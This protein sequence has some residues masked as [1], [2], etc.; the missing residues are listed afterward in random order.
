MAVP[1]TAQPGRGP[2]GLVALHVE[3]PP[4]RWRPARR[5][6]RGLGFRHLRIQVGEDPL[7]DGWVL[8]ARNDPHSTATGRAGLDVDPEDPLRALGPCHHGPAFGGRGLHRICGPRP[9]PS[10]APLRRCHPAR[11]SLL[12]A[13]TPW[14][15]VRLT[16]SSHETMAPTQPCRTTPP[17]GIGAFRCAQRSVRHGDVGAALAAKVA[18]PGTPAVFACKHAPSAP[19]EA[20]SQHGE[21]PCRGKPRPRS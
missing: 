6:A 1:L 15:R 8:N 7:D 4:L 10:P 18:W 9:L 12:G 13:N 14:N 3:Q 16:H 20:H 19:V 21:S 17:Q 5:P 2:P 11:Y